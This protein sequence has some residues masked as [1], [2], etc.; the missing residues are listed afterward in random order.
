MRIRDP[1]K[2]RLAL[3]ISFVIQ[4]KFIIDRK[5]ITI[6]IEIDNWLQ[7]NYKFHMELIIIVNKIQIL[8]QI[9][10]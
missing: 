5:S 2:Q 7:I 6:S 3:S 10:N 4:S 9:D 1:M 8:C